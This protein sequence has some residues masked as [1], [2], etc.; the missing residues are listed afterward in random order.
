MEPYVLLP[1]E[2]GLGN[3]AGVDVREGGTVALVE[4]GMEEVGYHH[5]HNMGVSISLGA[6]KSIPVSHGNE[7]SEALLEPVPVHE[8]PPV[9]CNH[10]PVYTYGITLYLACGTQKNIQMVISYLYVLTYNADTYVREMV[11]HV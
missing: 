11:T 2:R 9:S 7:V 5:G 3:A 10:K 6:N 1:E 4:L 8:V